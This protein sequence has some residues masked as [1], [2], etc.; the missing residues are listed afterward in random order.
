MSHSEE[1]ISIERT[2]TAHNLDKVFYEVII[3]IQFWLSWLLINI[4]LLRFIE[5][6]SRQEMKSSLL[7]FDSL[8]LNTFR[9]ASCA[10]GYPVCIKSDFFSNLKV[11]LVVTHEILKPFTL[12]YLEYFPQLILH[13]DSITNDTYLPERISMFLLRNTCVL[14]KSLKHSRL[15][16]LYLPA[17]CTL[18]LCGFL[19]LV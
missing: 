12:A 2:C 4:G 1:Y 11:S 5:M 14:R 16:S 7:K 6:R 3:N 13:Y 18:Q 8:G 9:Y 10:T 15:H 19:S 17:V